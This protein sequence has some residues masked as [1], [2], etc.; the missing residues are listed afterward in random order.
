MMDL[1]TG[2][3]KKNNLEDNLLKC[4]SSWE[5]TSSA[6]KCQPELEERDE[7]ILRFF[8]AKWPKVNVKT[9]HRLDAFPLVREGFRLLEA[10]GQSLNVPLL[11]EY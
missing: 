5:K 10:G 8:L 11:N 3:E 2:E 7:K 9:V 1:L 4:Q 6:G